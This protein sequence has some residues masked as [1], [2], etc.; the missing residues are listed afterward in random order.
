[1]CKLYFQNINFLAVILPL[2]VLAAVV[3]VKGV[4]V[5]LGVGVVVHGYMFLVTVPLTPHSAVMQ[6]TSPSVVL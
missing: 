6:F 5:G 1:M 4:D 2:V 3:N